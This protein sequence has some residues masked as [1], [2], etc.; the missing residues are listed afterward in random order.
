[1]SLIKKSVLWNC[2]LQVQLYIS[3]PDTI[4]DVFLENH[5]LVPLTFCTLTHK[6][7]YNFSTRHSRETLLRGNTKDTKNMKNTGI[8]AALKILKIGVQI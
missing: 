5:S 6:R 2:V 8:L 4:F 1:M 7:W 3:L